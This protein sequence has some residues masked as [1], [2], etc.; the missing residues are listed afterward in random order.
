MSH[1][2]HICALECTAVPV[3]YGSNALSLAILFYYLQS[4]Q[5]FTSNPWKSSFSLLHMFVS[6]ST[7]LSPHPLL[8][9]SAP[10]GE[11]GAVLVP[12]AH[13]SIHHHD[14]SL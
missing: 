5:P 10:R 1:A 2:A 7:H 9:V 3:Q 13:L 11:H 12:L 8:S 14:I 6:S 4:P